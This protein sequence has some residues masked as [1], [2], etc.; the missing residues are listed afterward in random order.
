[1]NRQTIPAQWRQRP[2]LAMGCRMAI[3]LEM[4]DQ[5]Q[6]DSLL[7]QAEAMVH[8]AERVLSRFDTTSELSRLNGRVGR[9]K[10]VSDLMWSV[11]TQALFMARE[12]GGLFDPTQLKA[13]ETAGYDRSF[14]EMTPALVIDEEQAAVDY[15]GQWREVELDAAARAV[16]LP[17]G[18]RLDLGGIAKGHTAQRVVDFLG[19]AG[20]CLVDA[21][22]DLTAGA[23]PRDWPAWPVAVGAPYGE[24]PY[25][26]PDGAPT[27]I[28]EDV[29]EL[30]LVD[31][32]MAT[33]GVDYRRWIR[34]G[35]PAH[36]VIDPRIG[37][38]AETDL[39]RA[40]VLARTAVRADAWAT[41][42]LVLGSAAALQQLAAKG[43]AAALIDQNERVILSPALTPILAA[44]RQE[45]IVEV[46]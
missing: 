35:R 30:W 1:M 8:D 4:A 29:F 19:Q 12:T 38:P 3:W 20:P 21:G 27:P 36:H 15:Q 26:G 7:D 11:I 45:S 24:A 39:L 5:R 41:A 16:R 14:D 40:T 6:A 9:W 33:S 10:P 31:G 28:D 18:V 43:F 25:G 23:A 46:N 37:G 13:L 32:T 42:A 17:A 44:A 2:F 34:N 22:G